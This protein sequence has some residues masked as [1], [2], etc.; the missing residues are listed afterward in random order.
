MK[1]LMRKDSNLMY[2]LTEK[3]ENN[4]TAR[5]Q[6]QSWRK[7]V[8]ENMNDILEYRR[9]ANEIHDLEQHCIT[10]ETLLAEKQELRDTAKASIEESISEV[11]GL[12]SHLES[13]KIWQAAAD[14]ISNKKSQAMNKSNTL[15]ISESVYNG[16]DLKTVERDLAEKT[17]KKDEHQEKVRL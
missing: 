6:Y 4:K 16:R 2:L 1:S 10:L 3:G 7:V 5:S 15:S 17:A 8:T 12:R 13:C 9:L 11:D 14:R